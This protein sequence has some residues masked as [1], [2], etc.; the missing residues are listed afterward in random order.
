MRR[1]R[2]HA[3]ARAGERRRRV[4]LEAARLITEG[5]VHD[6]AQARGKA[7]RRLGIHDPAS[8]PGQRDIEDAVREQQ[9]LFATGDADASLRLRREA[10]LEALGFFAAFSPRLVGPVLDGGAGPRTPVTLHLHHDDP[11]AIGRAL[12]EAGIPADLATRTVT[13]RGGARD[14]ALAWLFDAGGIAMEVV[15]LPGEALRRTAASA[16]D[17]TPM[18][19]ADAAQVRALLGTAADAGDSAGT[20]ATDQAAARVAQRLSRAT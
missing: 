14:E 11:D 3:D 18:R 5:A 4:A 10:A 12:D 2:Q 6:Y 1:D 17:D 7:A 13:W 8:L 19:R 15:A 9:R 16:V 20:G